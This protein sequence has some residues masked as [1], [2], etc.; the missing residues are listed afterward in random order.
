MTNTSVAEPSVQVKAIRLLSGDHLGD[1]SS[2][3]A[4]PAVPFVRLSTS[5]VRRSM[6]TRKDSLV[7]VEWLVKTIE[8]P[9]GESTG[10][11]LERASPVTTPS[12]QSSVHGVVSC[13]GRPF[14]AR[15]KICCSEPRSGTTVRG[16]W[17]GS[18]SARVTC[19][20]RLWPAGAAGPG[21]ASSRS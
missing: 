11:V 5:P 18:T 17:P 15:R 4:A 12:R 20:R 3:R 7:S 2:T 10:S 8:L 6:R 9:S 14:V 21:D 1:E 13:T 16:L 19:S